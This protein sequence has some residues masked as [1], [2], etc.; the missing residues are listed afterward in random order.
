[1][2]VRSA[3]NVAT[4]Q[5]GKVGLV[6]EAVQDGDLDLK[7][8]IIKN[9]AELP[10]SAGVWA[11]NSVVN[12]AFTA[13]T[14][15]TAVYIFLALIDGDGETGYGSPDNIISNQSTYMN[16]TTGEGQE[17]NAMCTVISIPESRT[18]YLSVKAVFT[19]GELT[20]QPISSPEYSLQAVKLG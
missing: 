5:S 12:V 4:T 7:T 1:M 10:L 6:M 18:I 9:V 2:S 8:G 15:L 17:Q 19:G 16:R 20:A 14:N 13:D 3:M 11:I